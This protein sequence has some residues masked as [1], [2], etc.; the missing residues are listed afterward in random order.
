M[1]ILVRGLELAASA[2]DDRVFL[3]SFRSDSGT[4]S[5]TRQ[6]ARRFNIVI[7]S[8]NEL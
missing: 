4:M 6:D 1:L 8:V 3:K 5:M 2:Q 7:G